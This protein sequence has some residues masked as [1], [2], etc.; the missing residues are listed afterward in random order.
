MNGLA[1]LGPP[2]EVAPAGKVSTGGK[3]VIS[4]GIAGAAALVLE[5]RAARLGIAALLGVTTLVVLR[6][7]DK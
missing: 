4:V 6:E 3:I 1:P 7:A 5:S 2:R